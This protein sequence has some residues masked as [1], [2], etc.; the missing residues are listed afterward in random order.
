MFSEINLNPDGKRVGDCVIRAIAYAM[1]YTWERAYIELMIEGFAEYDLPSSN[2][3]WDTYLRKHGFTR[4]AIPNTCPDCYT[5][6][7][8]CRDH[9]WGIYILAT[10]DH[11]LVAHNG[12]YIDSWDSGGEI[13]IY[14]YMKE[15][16][17]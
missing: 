17:A 11:V 1:Q 4:S 9:P 16:K 14:Y 10:G 3:V 5:V 15:E 2:R 13:P 12:D 7:D 8:F 6:R